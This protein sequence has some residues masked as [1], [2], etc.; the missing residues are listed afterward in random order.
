MRNAF[1]R[2]WAASYAEEIWDGDT[3]PWK[4]F[5]ADATTWEDSTQ[6]LEHDEPCARSFLNA[7]KMTPRCKLCLSKELYQAIFNDPII[8]K[9]SIPVIPLSPVTFM[10]NPFLNTLF[11]EFIYH[12]VNDVNLYDSF[13]SSSHAHVTRLAHGIYFT[14]QLSARIEF[15]DDSS[16]LKIVLY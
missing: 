1:F 9:L 16:D 11:R 7:Y 6:I 14:V 8:E 15:F 13:E 3:P 12:S 10:Q 2:N 4:M 5:P